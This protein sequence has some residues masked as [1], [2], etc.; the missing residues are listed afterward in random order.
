MHELS[1]DASTSTK[2]LIFKI[3]LRESDSQ[4]GWMR[5]RIKRGIWLIHSRKVARVGQA[6]SERA[7]VPKL[8]TEK[9]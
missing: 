8:Y 7:V 4:E 1:K 5:G 2:L 6:V 3:D 9:V